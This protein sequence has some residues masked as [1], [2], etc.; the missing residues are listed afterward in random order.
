[1]SELGNAVTDYLALRRSL[2]F[3]L[4]AHEPLLA[5]FVSYLERAGLDTVT[6]QAALSWATA[7]AAA[8]PSWWHQRLTPRQVLARQPD[9]QAPDRRRDARGRPPTE[10]VF[11][12]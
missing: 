1:M 2:G 5:G 11:L 4:R 6:T 12:G 3:K 8:G 9:H 10:A 7:P